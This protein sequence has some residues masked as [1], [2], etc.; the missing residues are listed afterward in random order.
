[1]KV[2]H[3]VSGEFRTGV[4]VKHS[5]LAR[6]LAVIPSILQLLCNVKSSYMLAGKTIT[7]FWL[8]ID[9]DSRNGSYTSLSRP[10]LWGIC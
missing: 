9:Q 8:Q 2:L 6:E 3:I 5:H 7:D 10:W 4:E 1:M